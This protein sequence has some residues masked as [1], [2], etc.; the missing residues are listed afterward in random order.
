VIGKYTKTTWPPIQQARKADSEAY[1]QT[2]VN[3]ARLAREEIYIE[4]PIVGRYT[5][6]SVS[7]QVEQTSVKL[8][9]L[10]LPRGIVPGTDDVRVVRPSRPPS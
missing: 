7:Y 8:S 5:S 3:L 4:G 2:N 1:K 6:T 10:S 9:E